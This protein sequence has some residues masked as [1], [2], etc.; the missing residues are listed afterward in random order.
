MLGTRVRIGE[1]FAVLWS[2][3]DLDAGTVDVTHT[4]VR[5]KGEG[6]LR[7]PTKPPR[8]AVTTTRSYSAA[9]ARCW[10]PRPS[11]L[12]PRSVRLAADTS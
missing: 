10:P 5:I 3:V 11:V 7:K 1:S 2:Q 9:Y 8:G 4:I 6:L 12:S